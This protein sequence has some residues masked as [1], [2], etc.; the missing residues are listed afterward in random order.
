MNEDI[1]TLHLIQWDNRAKL[2]GSE[3]TCLATIDGRLD[4]QALTFVA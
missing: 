1:G 2:P 4:Y 3:F